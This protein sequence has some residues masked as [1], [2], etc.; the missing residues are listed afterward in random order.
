MA[1]SVLFIFLM[2]IYAW[3]THCVGSSVVRLFL[4]ARVVVQ[5]HSPR[6]SGLIG[7]RKQS[8][9]TFKVFAVLPQLRQELEQ[10]EAENTGGA[11]KWLSTSTTTS[12]TKLRG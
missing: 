1:L 6:I 3:Q 12:T 2:R 4:H 11:T 5:V 8:T 9:L 10:A 7:G